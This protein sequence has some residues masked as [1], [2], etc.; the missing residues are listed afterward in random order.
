MYA[1]EENFCLTICIVTV[2]IA[3]KR[4]GIAYRLRSDLW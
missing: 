4:L 1:V 3:R 2:K